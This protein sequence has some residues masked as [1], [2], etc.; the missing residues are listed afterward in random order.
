[1]WGRSSVQ[2]L[3]LLLVLALFS[4]QG[5][6]A[7][8]TVNNASIGGRV[9]DPSG[10]AVARAMVAG[11]KTGTELSH[12]AKAGDAGRFRFPYLVVGKYEVTAQQQGFADARRLVTLTLGAAFQISIPLTIGASQETVDVSADAEVIEAARTQIAGTIGR[13]EVASLPLNG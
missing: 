10:A 5:L 3:W 11:R 8:E 12:V 1:Y 9:T 4:V 7:Q 6:R 2:H 13:Q